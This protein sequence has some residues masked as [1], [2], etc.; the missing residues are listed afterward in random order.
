MAETLA[1]R[2]Q[3]AAASIP[4]GR[5]IKPASPK[6]FR[7]SHIPYPAGVSCVAANLPPLP[8]VPLSRRKHPAQRAEML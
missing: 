6:A 1:D 3:E 5:D 4:A 2:I 8:A 7:T